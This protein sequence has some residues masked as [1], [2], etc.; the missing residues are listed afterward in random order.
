MAT[1]ATIRDRCYTQHNSDISVLVQKRKN[2]KNNN[3]K[4]KKRRI[5][6]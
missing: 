4:I 6:Q 2:N 3:M 1:T 5:R